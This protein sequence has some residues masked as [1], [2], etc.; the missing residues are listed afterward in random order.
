[1]YTHTLILQIYAIDKNKA[2]SV[3]LKKKN[4]TYSM[5]T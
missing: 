3:L 1:M 4:W 2:I 5:F